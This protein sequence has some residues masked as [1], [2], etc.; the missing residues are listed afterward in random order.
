MSILIRES[1]T[2]ESAHA[3]RAD[4]ERSGAGA[5]VGGAAIATEL[6]MKGIA[7]HGKDMLE[8]IGVSDDVGFLLQTPSPHEGYTPEGVEYAT[9]L[10]DLPTGADGKPLPYDKMIDAYLNRPEILER[11][12]E[13]LGKHDKI[14]DIAHFY[15]EA[16]VRG[17]LLEELAKEPGY[18]NL[19]ERVLQVTYFHSS[20]AL[21]IR[22]ESPEYFQ[23][24]N[25]SWERRMYEIATLKTSTVAFSTRQE[26]EIT[27]RAYDGV[28]GLTYEDIMKR[29][30]VAP[31]PINSEAFNVENPTEK[32]AE[33]RQKLGLKQ[34][35]T[36]LG[37]VTRIDTEKGYDVLIENF[38]Q[39]LNDL[40][41]QGADISNIQLAVLG[42]V[43][44]KD[45]RLMSRAQEMKQY[46]ASLPEDIQSQIIFPGVAMSAS[47]VMFAFDAY[48]G[49]S[50]TETLH[51]APKE[52]GLCQVQ[53]E[54]DGTT[55]THG[56]P[57]FLSKI[58]A[59]EETHPN[60]SAFFFDKDSYESHELKD[61]KTGEMVH[62]AGFKEAFE[63]ALSP[64]H[65]A[66]Y[67]GR[68]H[69]N[70]QRF[71]LEQSTWTLLDEIDKNLKSQDSNFTLS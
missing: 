9:E 2:Q 32:R 42:G 12:R 57:A 46:I 47:E 26:R 45:P 1:I 51:L 70:S 61:D 11:Y 22:A 31:L 21:T 40:K 56:I 64:K 18:E 14:I 71:G 28:Y 62:V 6:Q 25:T 36:V 3:F 58:A 67:G 50:Q 33:A 30:V 43:P 19:A 24:S 65:R 35:A 37:M 8:E 20:P 44:L 27:A 60:D 39:W 38:V 59:H 66:Y 68:N 10:F 16:A 29:S 49:P 69:H 15:V 41:E 53:S 13:L 17:A 52:A 4:L 63:T 7:L 55:I 23:N 54:I 34:D 5:S 48:F